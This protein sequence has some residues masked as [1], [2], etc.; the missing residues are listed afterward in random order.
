MRTFILILLTA[1]GIAPWIQAAE[2]N[3]EDR[4]AIR[5]IEGLPP[6]EYLVTRNA[7]RTIDGNDFPIA[8]V[9]P[10]QSEPE[11]KVDKAINKSETLL[12]QLQDLLTAILGG[13]TLILGIIAKIKMNQ[14]RTLPALI[15]AVEEFQSQ[16]L[17]AK[18]KSN[19]EIAG[20]EK[21]LSRLVESETQMIKK[22][23]V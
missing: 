7:I 1:L 5:G 2:L 8:Q 6:G 17:K 12:E 3:Q 22:G 20:V 15:R 14:A 9:T 19:A 11:S 23:S 10:T 16:E 4:P 21:T 18:I 13:V